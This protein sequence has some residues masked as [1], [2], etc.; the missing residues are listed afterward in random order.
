VPLVV[1]GATDGAYLRAAGIP[2]HGVQGLFYDR[3][4]IRLQGRDEWLK[5]QSF[6]EGQ[7]FTYELVKRLSRPAEA[8]RSACTGAA[9]TKTGIRRPAAL[10]RAQF[11]RRS[12]GK[13]AVAKNLRGVHET[14]PN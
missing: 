11:P 9:L 1:M 7:T 3:D 8:W 14:C 5:V 10:L 2:T 13:F 4:D 6:C 12:L